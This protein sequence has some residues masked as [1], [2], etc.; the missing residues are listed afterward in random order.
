MY[1]VINSLSKELVSFINVDSNTLLELSILN[2]G[3]DELKKNDLVTSRLK[4]ISL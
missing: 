3:I 4:I 2:I 1:E